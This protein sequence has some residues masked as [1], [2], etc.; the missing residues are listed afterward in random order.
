M[1]S[2][3][4]IILLLITVFYAYLKFDVLRNKKDVNVLSTIKDSYFTDDDHFSY[5]QG[6]NIAVAFTKY[7]SEREPILIPQI[8]EIVINQYKWGFNEDGSVFSARVPLQDHECTKDELNLSDDAEDP[9]FFKPHPLSKPTIELY[10][11]KFRC[12]DTS[13]LDIYGDFNTPKATLLNI[14]LK[15]CSGRDDCLPDSKIEE[16]LQ[17]KYLLLVMNQV[18]FDSE[19]YGEEAIIK[20]SKVKW[21][22]IN[23]QTRVTYP[24]A[25]NKQL[26]LL[27]DKL[28]NFDDYTE[29]EN[30]DVFRFNELPS[31]SYEKYGEQDLPVQMNLTFERDMNL[32]VVVRD[33]YTVLDWI[34]DIGG[35]QGILISAI[36]IMIGYWNYNYFD[37]NMVE[38]LYKIQ[39]DKSAGQNRKPREGK[40]DGDVMT[41]SL[42]GGL[43]DAF[44][45]LIPA[46]M[47]CC[48]SGRNDRG[49]SKGRDKLSQET[50]IIK[51][52]RSRRYFNAA[53]KQLITKK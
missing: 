43:R 24:F 42:C 29:L 8:G 38:Q 25:L 1:G 28:F 37:N 51:I 3:C 19:N 18:R 12:L 4:S 2:I 27:Q 40:Q 49:L 16:F 21:L 44:C 30:E 33:G 5:E 47:Q 20:E 34:S 17:N 7:D 46:F 53:L 48:R 36:A 45:D 11:K 23:T 9:K 26:L 32:V 13:D 52:I 50:N 14:Q 15:K 35:I 41:V 31:Q 6:L 22:T 39:R 10:Q